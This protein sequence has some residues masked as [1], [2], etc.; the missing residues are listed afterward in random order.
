MGVWNTLGLS[1]AR[2]SSA[3]EKLHKQNETGH[4]V[5][6]MATF[7]KFFSVPYS[8]AV[9]LLL[10]LGKKIWFIK[11]FILRHLSWICQAPRL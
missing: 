6:A 9:L 4:W 5:A 7:S 11:P 3:A 2:C 10:Y 8:V 1:P